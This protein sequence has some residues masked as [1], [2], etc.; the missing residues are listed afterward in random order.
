MTYVYHYV[1]C[2][3]V[4]FFV[5]LSLRT[6]PTIALLAG[7]A[8]AVGYLIYEL[9]PEAKVGFLLSA[10]VLTILAEC[11][12]RLCKK[13]ATIFIVL[14]IYPLVP[15]IALYQTMAFAIQGRYNR[16]LEKGAEAL[17]CIVLMTVAI[18]LVPTIFRIL[19]R[20]RKNQ[21]E[22]G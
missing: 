11:L 16:A 12:A 17:I 5:G 13:P 14:G 15:G 10:L 20:R 21:N 9:C 22:N 8:G 3:A 19:L 18:A 1:I 2:V 4:I 7:L 6:K